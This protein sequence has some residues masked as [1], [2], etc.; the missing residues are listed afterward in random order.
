MSATEEKRNGFHSARAFHRTTALPPLDVYE[1]K[2]EVLVVVDVPGVSADA[3]H[4][5][6]EGDVLK[7]EAQGA[8]RPREQRRYERTLKIP[9]GIDAARIT[10]E[11]KN[12]TVVIHMPKLEQAKPRRILVKGG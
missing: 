1:S 8:E 2:E 5:E 11:T 3:L 10:A 4:I 6:V 9:K 7:F 12:G